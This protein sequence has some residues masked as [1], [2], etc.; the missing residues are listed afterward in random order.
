MGFSEGFSKHVS[1]GLARKVVGCCRQVLKRVKDVQGR[2]V[3]DGNF[4]FADFLRIPEESSRGSK[5]F[6]TAFQVE[7]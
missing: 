3:S 5:A 2:G 6:Q 7:Y 4:F 1:D